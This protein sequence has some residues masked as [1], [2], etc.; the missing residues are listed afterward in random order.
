MTIIV[1]PLLRHSLQTG[2]GEGEGD[3]RV[4]VRCLLGQYGFGYVIQRRFEDHPVEDRWQ[5]I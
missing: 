1:F 5:G 4:S 2:E 3:K